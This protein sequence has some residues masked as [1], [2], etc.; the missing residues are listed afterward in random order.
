[1]AKQRDEAKIRQRSNTV[2][3][4]ESSVFDA[5]LSTC[6]CGDSSDLAEHSLKD[7]NDKS[8]AQ[9]RP[10]DAGDDSP[11]K[12]WERLSDV[13]L[14]L[15]GSAPPVRFVRCFECSSVDGSELTIPRVL[16][17]L[18]N[19]HDRCNRSKVHSMW[20]ISEDP[21]TQELTSFDTTRSGTSDDHMLNP[22]SAQGPEKIRLRRRI[23]LRSFRSGGSRSSKSTGTKSTAA[24]TVDSYLGKS[25]GGTSH[26]VA[27]PRTGGGRQKKQA[28]TKRNRLQRSPTQSNMVRI[29]NMV[30]IEI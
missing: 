9:P 20:S 7:K 19:E 6:C 3:T 17:D 4:E 18:A 30:R 22:A 8:K 11:R 15:V 29:G 16:T 13:A 14:F 25:C 23:R 1:M 10:E 24:C 26:N 21:S 2:A 5:I 27:K 28:N 12:L